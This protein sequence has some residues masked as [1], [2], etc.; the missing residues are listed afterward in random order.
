M[1][2][3]SATTIQTR[4]LQRLPTFARRF[5]YHTFHDA[6]SAKLIRLYRNFIFD[7]GHTLRYP[8]SRKDWRQKLSRSLTLGHCGSLIKVRL[9]HAVRFVL[10]VKMIH[11]Q[12]TLIMQ[13]KVHRATVF[14]I[15]RHT[16]GRAAIFKLADNFGLKRAV[17]HELYLQS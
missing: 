2:I 10:A 12:G 15:V 16:S 6:L 9:V 4:R 13:C 8:R 5:R 3:S 7:C 1:L 14:V 11:R 17:N